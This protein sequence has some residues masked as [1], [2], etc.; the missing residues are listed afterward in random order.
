MMNTSLLIAA[1][2]IVPAVEAEESVHFDAVERGRILQ[3]S[4]VPDPPDDATNRFQKNARAARL[5]QFLFFDPRLSGNGKISCA[6]CHEPGKSFA[7][8]KSLSEGVA[9]GDRH[10]LSLWNVAYNRW[11]FWDGRADTLWGQ[12]AGPIESPKEMNGSRTA[13]L[14]LIIKDTSLRTAYERIFGPVVD[15]P[16]EAVMAN[17]GKAIAAYETKLISRDAPFDRFVVQ[18][19]DDKE[20][21]AISPSAQRGLKL[22]IGRGNCRQCHV[23]PLFTDG[24]FHNIRVPPKGGG[25]PSDAG[26]F[27]GIDALMA[28]AFNSAGKWS[29][30]QDSAR[31]RRL[32]YL[33]K[34][35]DLW[36]AFKTPSLRNVA[37]TAPYMHQGQ[38]ASL[39]DVMSYYSTLEGAVVMGHHPEKIL[40]PLFLSDEESADLI[41]FLE[42]LTDE[43]I[44]PELTRPP[45]SP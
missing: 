40:K 6:T 5:G 9:T 44:D 13:V 24:E 16:S 25:E 38:F 34:T 26:R 31:A 35:P 23:G 18:L 29:D 33:T 37:R 43:S 27:G 2:L 8:G 19:R 36:G 17:V 32:R 30:G 42:S 14:Q 7:D 45:D 21:T 15:S 22:F 1:L 10:T 3:H 28:N 12:I 41:A 20:L 11:Y 4:P 39:S